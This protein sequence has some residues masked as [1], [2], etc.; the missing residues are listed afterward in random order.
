M[1]KD[2]DIRVDKIRVYEHLMREIE[3]CENCPFRDMERF[4]QETTF[5]KDNETVIDVYIE[6]IHYRVCKRI[7]DMYNKEE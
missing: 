1:I 3:C 7:Y 2:N 5:L 4:K 6:C